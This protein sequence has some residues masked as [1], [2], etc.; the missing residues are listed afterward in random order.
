MNAIQK[1]KLE[2]GNDSMT[3]EESIE[4]VVNNMGEITKPHKKQTELVIL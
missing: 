1:E 3:K 2:C 4:S